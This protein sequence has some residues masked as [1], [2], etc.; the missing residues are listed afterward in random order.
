MRLAIRADATGAIGAGHLVRMTAL[1]QAW[2]AGGRPVV[3]LSRIESD[4]LAQGL[5]VQGFQL[6][7]LAAMPQEQEVDALLAAT[8]PGDW[9]A[10]D[11]YGFNIGMQRP[12]RQAGRKLLVVDDINDRG[13]LHADILLNQ[14]L[15]AKALRYQTN[16]GAMRLL[17]TEFALLR[18]AFL[19][20]ALHRREHPARA[21][22]ILVMFG[23]FDTGN[24]SARVLEALTL[25]DASDIQAR[26]VACGSPKRCAALRDQARRAK[27]PVRILDFVEDMPELMGWADIAIS[28]AGSTCWEMCCLGLP[29]LITAVAPNQ[30]LIARGLHAAGAA[31]AFTPDLGLDKFSQSIRFLMDSQGQ[32]QALAEA[33]RLLVDGQGPYRVARAMESLS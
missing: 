3:F 18:Q 23:G 16:A 27:Y 22:N 1:A 2:A 10:L 33:A 29:A 26:I 32:R 28:S 7:D 6:A 30:A 17:G 21:T 20:A 4:D 9:I 14:N 13:E 8:E 5:R 25:L 24:M 11:G 31:I 12:L 15:D 19:A